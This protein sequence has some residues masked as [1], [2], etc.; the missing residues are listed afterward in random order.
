[1]PYYWRLSS[2]YLFYFALLGT[3][4]P[5]W[6]LYLR[7]AGFAAAQI[8]LLMAIPQ[9]TKLGA[10]NLWGWLADRTGQRLRVIRTGNLLAAIVFTGV[11]VADGFWS[12]VIVLAG[13]SFFWNAVLAQFEVITLETLGDRSHRYSQV[14]LWGSVGFIAAVLAVGALLDVLPVS[15]LPW[16]L[17]GSL[18]LI[19]FCTLFLPAG[20]ATARVHGGGSLWAILKQPG[21]LAFFACAFLMQ[22]SHGP[23]YT[24]YTIHLVDLGISRTVAGTLWAL[25]VVAEVG[26]FLLMHWLLVRVPLKV[27]VVSSLLLA[28]LRW[29]LIG[30]VGDSLLWLALAQLLHAATFGS[31]HAAAM[32]WLH[33]TFTGGHAGQGQALYSSLG[34]GAGWAVGAGL[35]GVVWTALGAD[36]FYLAAL[37]ALLAAGLAAVR[38]R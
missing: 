31:F 13:F 9:I 26:L 30:S 18:W 24:F 5:Y 34:F 37:V 33:R 29:L 3:L 23:Y 36:S 12:M 27:I 15:V 2:F 10:P 6:S 8:G 11:F 20:S 25:G 7:D 21:V 28:S 17:W 35:S 1:M 22:L 32:A 38:L 19:W 4:V 16:L 14:R